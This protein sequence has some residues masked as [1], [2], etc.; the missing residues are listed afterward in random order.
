[1]TA[2]QTIDIEALLSWAY[3]DQCVDKMCQVF[4]PKGPSASPA[5]NL[6]QYLTL[7]CRVDSSN[8]AARII[9]SGNVADDAVTLHDA[10]LALD[11]IF[12]E[13]E[14]D[15]RLKLWTHEAAADEGFTICERNGGNGK[16]YWKHDREMKA[17]C[18]LDF[19]SLSTLIISHAKAG[20]RPEW[21]EGWRPV[22]GKKVRAGKTVDRRGRRLKT[23]MVDDYTVSRDRGIYRVWWWG[24]ELLTATLTGDLDRFTLT[25][26]SAL[27]E[28]WLIDSPAKTAKK[29]QIYSCL[30]SLNLQT[31]NNA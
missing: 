11:D 26:P 17:L 22:R 10:V 24:L 29:C 25:G 16:T 20:D 4:K 23:R 9:G 3:R 31:K 18:R 13:W 7:G 1:M 19:I 8:V 12:I 30:N 5:N 15:S 27:A 28:P 14:T 6:A 2:K 21:H